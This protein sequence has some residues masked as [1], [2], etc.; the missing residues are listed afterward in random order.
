MIHRL[1]L[2]L[3]GC[4]LALA[5]PVSAHTP[6]SGRMFGPPPV[7]LFGVEFSIE[8]DCGPLTLHLDGLHDRAGPCRGVLVRQNPWSSFDP[9][10]LQTAGEYFHE[11]GNY[12]KG[13]GDVTV[14]AVGALAN[15]VRSLP[16]N[17]VGVISETMEL[18][19]MDRSSVWQ[20]IKN[21]G[22]QIKQSTSQAVSDFGD[23][24]AD[25]DCRAYGQVTGTVLT[26]GGS[27][28]A[29]FAKGA[30]VAEITEAAQV[31]TARTIAQNQSTLL[32]ADR[33]PVPAPP[34]NVLPPSGNTIVVS[35]GGTAV[36]VPSGATGPLPVVNPAG[37]TT[38]FHFSGGSGGLGLDKKAT[39]VRFMD[40]TP[41]KGASP[42]YANGYATYQ[43][44]S[45]QG[46]DPATGKTVPNSHP[47]RHIPLQ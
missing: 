12:W 1:L 22:V 26:L 31:G 29:Q 2:A 47:T 9:E 23:R 3:L 17:T 38:G 39:G 33:P 10:G 11:M 32:L 30:V 46:V 5:A 25:G 42:G 18:S 6:I 36:I 28:G 41:P 16:I 27:K 15:A 35:P 45:G 24:L 34:V 21:Q 7:T 43:N 19:K 4:L 40:P 14:G 20:G 13:I 8:Q 44:A 37:K